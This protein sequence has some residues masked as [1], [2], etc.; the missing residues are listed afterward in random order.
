MIVDTHNDLLTELAFRSEEPTPFRR[1]W[2]DQLRA[3]RVGLQVCPLYV[4]PHQIPDNALHLALRQVAA[5]HRAV[6]E[7][8]GSTV[9]VKTA[10]DLVRHRPG[11]PNGPHALHGGRG[12]GRA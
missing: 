3:G 10:A 7:S 12:A 5:C 9:L 1:Y 11:D 6:S 2:H 4:P 8:A